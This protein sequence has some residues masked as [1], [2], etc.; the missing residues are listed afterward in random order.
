MFIRPSWKNPERY[1]EF[2]DP[3][4]RHFVAWEFLCRNL[5]YQQ[6]YQ[7]YVTE[8]VRWSSEHPDFQHIEL[9]C[10]W[11]FPEGE[12]ARAIHAFEFGNPSRF[13]ELRE[14]FY[15]R[16]KVGWMF[17]PNSG[18]GG[19]A[20]VMD[21]YERP[22]MFKPVDL[23]RSYEMD[24]PRVMIPV[25]LSESLETLESRVMWTVK[26]LRTEGIERGVITPR[27]SRVLAPRVYVEHLRILD[28]SFVG[29]DIREIGEVLQ[30]LGIN[31]PEARQRD[32]RI[33]AALRAAQS[34]QDGGYR[35]LLTD[36]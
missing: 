20:F 18:V 6:D 31:D 11:D 7:D 13:N 30:P 17:A 28:A 2:L 19:E 23:Y 26:R 24:G 27:L 16:W 15:K 10:S 34:M 32:K 12:L 8:A 14:T 25:D 22:E 5:N 3:D 9:E 29:A 33:R 35:I 21:A 1:R 4:L 36:S